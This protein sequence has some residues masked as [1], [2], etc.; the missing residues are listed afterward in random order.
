MAK[1][2]KVD[3]EK[4]LDELTQIVETM[5]KGDLSLEQSLKQF[6]KGVQLTRQCQS[7]LK[8][9]EQSI[10]ILMKDNEQTTLE[11]YDDN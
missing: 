11:P 6:E 5:E 9:A 8:E 1:P 4:S 10:Q 7:A 2:K 3:F